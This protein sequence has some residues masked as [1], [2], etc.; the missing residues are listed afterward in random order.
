M[1]Y[2]IKLFVCAPCRLFMTIFGA[3]LFLY[4]FIFIVILPDILFCCQS[5]VFLPLVAIAVELL[6]SHT[7]VA[8]L[9]SRRA[10]FSHST[11]E[12]RDVR[13]LAQIQR[14]I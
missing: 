13:C 11:V 7:D 10:A 9:S 5:P 8:L 14:R 2:L 4:L 3:D 1:R 6:A 12:A